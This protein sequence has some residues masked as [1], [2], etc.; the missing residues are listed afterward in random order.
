[1]YTPCLTKV[2]D[3]MRL[4]VCWASVNNS[5]MKGMNGMHTFVCFVMMQ[6]QMRWGQSDQVGISCLKKEIV[7][8]NVRTISGQK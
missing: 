1:M 6:H 3:W 7:H 8:K 4:E 2:T 5:E